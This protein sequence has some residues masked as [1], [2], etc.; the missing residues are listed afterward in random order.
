MRSWVLVTLLLGAAPSVAQDAGV[1]TKAPALLKKVPAAFPA[2]M[3]DAGTSGTVVLQVDVGADGTVTHAEVVKSAGAS[4]DDAALAAVRQFL[5]S[6]AEVDGVPAPVRLQFSQEF[7]FRPELV[8]SPPSPDAGPKARANF[9]GRIVERGT[10]DAL[11]GAHIVL[12]AN[13]QVLEADAD[14][15]GA[16]V[17]ENVPLGTWPV[18]VLA[19][20]YEPYKV[21][22]DFAAGKQTQV[23][24][25]VRR[26]VYGGYET[27]VRAKRER[28]EVAQVTLKQEEIRLIPGTNGDA[29]R[30]VQNL[31]GVARSAFGLGFLVVRG[32]KPFD[33]KVYVDEAQVP[34]LFHFGGIFSTYNSWLLE[35]LTFQQGNFNADFGRAIGGFVQ[36]KTRTPS[37]KGV[38][39][40]FDINVV[41]AS[42][43]VEFP[44]GKDWSMAVS[45]RR[46]YVDALVPAVLKL[47]P[48][49]EE[50]IS[51]T[52]APRYLD[53]QLKLEYRPKGSKHRFFLSFFGSNDELVA[54]LP[55]P[56]L[57]PEGRGTFGTS[58]LY[59]RL[60]AGYD[61]ALDK[62]VS[63]RTRTSVGLDRFA[64]TLGSDIFLKAHSYPLLSRNTFSFDLPEVKAQLQLGA[65]VALL[66]YEISRQSPPPP[67]ANQVPDPFASRNLVAEKSFVFQAEP[68][69]FFD[70]LLKPFDSLRVVTG[71]RL[72]YNSVMRDVWMDPRVSVL[73]QL[74]PAWALKGGIGLYH[75]SPDFRQGQ[76]SPTFGN[77]D[78]LAEGSRQYMVGSEVRFTDAISLDVQLYYKDLFAQARPT[79]GVEAG[80]D[81][82]Q[83]STQKPYES[84]GAGRSFGAEILLRHSLTKNFFGWVA[85]S[86]SRTERDYRGGTEWG[87]SGFDQ[88]HNLIV[89]AS[90]KLPLDFI[91]GAKLRYTSGPLTTPIVGAVYDA[92][93]NY[94]FPIPGA[95][96]SRRLPDFFQ[97]DVRVDKRF[98]FKDW[99]LALY[100]DV[101]NVTN[102][103]N[104][105]GVLNSYDYSQEAF[106]TGLPILPVLG[107]RGEW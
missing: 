101:Q 84:F 57:D 70:L 2:D 42:A 107:M 51:F 25:Y 75:Q 102:R 21:T 92:N 32:G 10:R 52:V 87:P 27:V 65:D 40:Y 28:K 80:A 34:I 47:I 39:G 6:P 8:E 78:L 61:V 33:T 38:H 54:A 4:F 95:P 49:G 64:F 67:R 23:T 35:E 77:P 17:L 11:A 72:D 63:F 16:F 53:Y 104:V 44:L 50:A 46:S 22:E 81:L 99:M 74:S 90:Y 69:V 29:F 98:V 91:V 48:G 86:L 43:L 89:V 18:A 1:L 103:Q 59:N 19:P 13:E 56:S 58:I 62:Q 3:A 60:L 15:T 76:L 79:T 30:V 14:D 100:V 97:L 88:P 105:E 85:Y 94:Y 7:F 93:G 45:A 20:D 12:T 37:K 83:S 5:F 41:D 24:Y 31:P 66:P 26:R 96:N 68:A 82:T 9:T 106:V 71:L 55:N 73:W 36:G